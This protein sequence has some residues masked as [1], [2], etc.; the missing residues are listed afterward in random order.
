M[1]KMM[2]MAMSSVLVLR[3]FSSL[4]AVRQSVAAAFN[5]IRLAATAV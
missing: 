5:S 1:V 3:S 2:E 4:A